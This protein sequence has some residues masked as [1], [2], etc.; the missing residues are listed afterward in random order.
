MKPCPEF[1]EPSLEMIKAEGV[2]GGNPQF[3]VRIR[4]GLDLVEVWGLSWGAESLTWGSDSKPGGHCQNRLGLPPIGV[5]RLRKVGVVLEQPPPP[6]RGCDRQ[7][8]VD[9][10]VH[11]LEWT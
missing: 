8:A 6:T 4:G 9:I 5:Q 11:C 1:C 2:G 3:T 10:C 7:T